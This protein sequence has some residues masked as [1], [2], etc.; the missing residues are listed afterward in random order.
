[1]EIIKSMLFNAFMAVVVWYIPQ[2]IFGFIAGF[3][4][5]GLNTTIEECAGILIIGAIIISI[6]SEFMY[7]KYRIENYIKRALLQALEIFTKYIIEIKEVLYY[8]R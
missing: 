5:A 4:I 3:V 7:W 2:F 1:M 6:I 8:D